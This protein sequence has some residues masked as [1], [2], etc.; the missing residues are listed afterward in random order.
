MALQGIE[1]EGVIIKVYPPREGTSQRTGNPWKSQD[2]VIQTKDQYPRTCLFHV[3]GE[4]RLR[5]F[6]IEQGK[7]YRV[8]I[9]INAHA[10]QD[11]YFNDISATSVVPIDA[12]AVG[13]SD[14][15]PPAQTNIG[16]GGAQSQS[17]QDPLGGGNSAD[18]G[19]DLPF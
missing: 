13:G 6:N 15:V 16:N 12:N 2:F 10:W 7:S 8:M 14:V 18:D 5:Q 17:A 11:R 4:D 19:S 3:F 9:E 1:V